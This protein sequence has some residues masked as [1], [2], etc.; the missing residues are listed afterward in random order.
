[1]F[2]NDPTE[3]GVMGLPNG[4]GQIIGGVILPAL[5]H[6]MKYARVQ[7]IVSL[8]FQTLF[9]GLYA[10]ASPNH[11]GAWMAFQL[12]GQ[13]CFGWMTICCYVIAGLHVPH[14][15]LGIATGLLG[16]FRE[17]GGSVGNAIFST[18]LNSVA[19][20]KVAPQ[21]AAAAVAAGFNPADLATLI[22]AAYNNAIGVPGAFAKVP[23]ITPSIEAEVARAFKQAYGQAFR[24]VF[25][26]TIPFNV[27]ALVA[28][29]F[30]KDVSQYFTNHVTLHLEK[31]ILGRQHD[32]HTLPKRKGESLALE[33]RSREDAPSLSH[34]GALQE[35]KEGHAA[36][37]HLEVAESKLKVNMRSGD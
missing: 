31:D 6:K 14:R 18:I 37:R 21:I 16:T 29:C 25:Y 32:D 8:I 30:I 20:K 5:V 19:S 22:P 35:N 3:I 13:G 28:A 12:F 34:N 26:S 36:E 2:T 11:K 17:G 4:A 7:I 23:G 15:E 33:R 27:L 10:Y 9:N 1:M 24:V